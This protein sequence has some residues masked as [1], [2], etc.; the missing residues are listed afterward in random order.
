MNTDN[1]YL[2]LY[3]RE[4]VHLQLKVTFVTDFKAEKMYITIIECDSHYYLPVFT[5]WM[6]RER[7]DVSVLG[8]LFRV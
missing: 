1:W 7:R 5:E 3:R 2:Y 8:Y 6:S 4:I